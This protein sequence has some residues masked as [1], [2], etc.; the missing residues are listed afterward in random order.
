MHAEHERLAA[1]PVC[2][3]PEMSDLYEASGQSMQ[4]AV[5]P[6]TAEHVDDLV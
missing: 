2:R 1:I 6:A 4:Q 5:C 3:E